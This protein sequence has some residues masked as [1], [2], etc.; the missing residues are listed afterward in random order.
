[1]KPGNGRRLRLRM[2]PEVGAPG[3]AAGAAYP[4]MP[5]YTANGNGGGFAG[6]TKGTD[7]LSEAGQRAR[8]Q[9]L[10][11]A[12]WW[13]QGMTPELALAVHACKAGVPRSHI[14]DGNVEGATLLE[15]YTCDGVVR[16]RERDAP[17]AGD[18]AAAPPPQPPAPA[19]ARRAL[20]VDAMCPSPSRP[21]P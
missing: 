20:S 8:V 19:A 14:L 1:M 12:S 9:S 18:A 11:M 2:L 6:G 15:L 4:G 16:E 3:G 21:S 17:A 5:A 13:E 7:D 10:A